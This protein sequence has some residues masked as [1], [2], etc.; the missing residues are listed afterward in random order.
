MRITRHLL[1]P[2]D[3]AR[4]MRPAVRAALC[5]SVR[6]SRLL[7]PFNV[8]LQ[9]EGKL[10]QGNHD[11]Y[12]CSLQMITLVLNAHADI[13]TLPSFILSLLIQ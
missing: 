2:G 6:A 9:H 1:A 4:F 12:F 8:A 13:I 10:Y 11:V 3:K 5:V 7:G